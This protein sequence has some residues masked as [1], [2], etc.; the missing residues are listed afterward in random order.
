MKF[1]AAWILSFL[2]IVGCGQQQTDPI[3]SDI[4]DY[5]DAE[6]AQDWEKLY[7]LRREKFKEMVS[8]DV[9]LRI[10]DES[11]DESKLLSY[12]IVSVSIEDG[13]ATAIVDFTHEQYTFDELPVEF[14]QRA[15]T[16]WVKSGDRWL[17][18]DSSHFFKV[19]GQIVYDS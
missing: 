12:R 18:L 16:K 11:L 19:F 10:M 14:N 17:F 7:E 13:S 3:Y 4:S 1:A 6:I 5:F 8:K 9:F 2:F 15:S